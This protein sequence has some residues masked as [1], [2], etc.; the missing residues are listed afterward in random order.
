MM[1]FYTLLIS[2][3]SIRLV[4][5]SP[6]EARNDHALDDWLNQSLGAMTEIDNLNKNPGDDC[7]VVSVEGATLR[8][9]SSYPRD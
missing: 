9:K 5:A 6:A 1:N 7:T 2:F 8:G 3:V 4:L